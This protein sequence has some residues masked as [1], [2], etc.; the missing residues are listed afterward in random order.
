[1]TFLFGNALANREKLLAV[2]GL[3]RGMDKRALRMLQQELRQEIVD[4][5]AKH[6]EWGMQ[7]QYL[8]LF[9][10]PVRRPALAP[11]PAQLNQPFKY[12]W[13]LAVPSIV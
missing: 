10:I 8:E 9:D 12:S 3:F 1:M 6:E 7:R 5:L 4:V 2:C 13:D 11:Q